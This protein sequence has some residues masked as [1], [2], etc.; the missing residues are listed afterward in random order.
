[1]F[2]I[3]S[4][5]GYLCVVVLKSFAQDKQQLSWF[6]VGGTI[7]AQFL[8]YPRIYFSTMLTNKAF[9]VLFSMTFVTFYLAMILCSPYKLCGIK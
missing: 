6:V 3:I 5:P 4:Q 8:P 7:S 9:M 1:M 2:L